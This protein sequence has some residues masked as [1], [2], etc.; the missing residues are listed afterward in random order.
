MLIKNTHKRVKMRLLAALGIILLTTMKKPGNISNFGDRL[1]ESCW[2][3][4]R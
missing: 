3:E 2:N 1:W 4:V